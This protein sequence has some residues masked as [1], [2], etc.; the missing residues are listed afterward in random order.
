M[1]F[2]LIDSSIFFSN[3]SLLVVL[4]RPGS[5]CTTLLKILANHRSEYHDVTGQVHYDSF[6]PSE[7]NKHFRGDVQYCPEDDILFPTLTVDETIRFAAKTRAPQPRIQG[8]TRKQYTRLITDVYLT[9]FGLKHVNNTLVGD[10][11][12][13]GVS[14]GEK[15][16]VSISETLAT[17]SLITSWDKYVNFLYISLSIPLA[18]HS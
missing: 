18:N 9:I 14:G 15:K 1:S 2:P 10:A 7:I 13:R 17:R 4:G 12:I 5:G 6:S 8:M 3:L 11:A 16:R